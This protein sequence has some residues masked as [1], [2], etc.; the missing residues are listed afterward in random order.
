MRLIDFSVTNGELFTGEPTPTAAR[1]AKILHATAKEGAPYGLMT[2]CEMF[3]PHASKAPSIEDKME[4]FGQVIET[5]LRKYKWQMHAT[6]GFYAM[7]GSL[8][9]SVPMVL[10]FATPQ[11]VA[12]N[13]EGMTRIV[14]ILTGEKIQPSTLR[15]TLSRLVQQGAFKRSGEGL[16]VRAGLG[17]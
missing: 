10:T 17:D 12:T 11:G 7:P 13:I 14:E 15:K 16:Y 5:L 2:L 4:L 8:K 9:T 3:V 1:C 6:Y